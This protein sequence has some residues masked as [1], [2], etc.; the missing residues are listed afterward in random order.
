[1]YLHVGDAVNGGPAIHV[2]E[3]LL[4][5]PGSCVEVT[6]C[7]KEIYDRPQLIH[8]VYV[9]SSLEVPSLTNRS[10]SELCYL[11]DVVKQHLWALAV[12]EYAP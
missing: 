5:T 11:H 9:C 4:Q 1:M 10:G 8:Q 7:V 2:S 6:G 3:G 12:M